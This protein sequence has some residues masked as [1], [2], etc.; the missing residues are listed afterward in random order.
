MYNIH[1]LTWDNELLDILGVPK[2]MLPEVRPMFGNLRRDDQ[3][4]FSR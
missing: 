1:E 3:L 4:S 2:S